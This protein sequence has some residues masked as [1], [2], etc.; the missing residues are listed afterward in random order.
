MASFDDLE[1]VAQDL[2][3]GK[4]SSSA[5]MSRTETKPHEPIPGPVSPH[6]AEVREEPEVSG[7]ASAPA[8][9]EPEPPKPE[10][11]A[12]DKAKEEERKEEEGKRGLGRLFGRKKK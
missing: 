6:R 5:F 1:A 9:G 11:M 7:P 12:E 3:H 2:A 8:E 10:P 4:A